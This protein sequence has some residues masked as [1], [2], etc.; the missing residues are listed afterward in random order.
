MLV[1][2]DQLF[3]VA[4]RHDYW[5]YFRGQDAVLL[6]GHRALVRRHRELV[7]LLTRNAVLAAQVF[8]GLQHPARHRV[9]PAAGRRAAPSQPVV[10]LDT[11]AGATPAHIGGIEGDVAHA[12]ATAGDDQV[13][14]AAGHLQA[15]LDHR[16]QARPAAAVDLHA[17]NRHRQAGIQRHDASDRGGLAAGVAVPQDDVLHRVGRQPGSV[18]Q[19][20]EGRDAEVN[21]TEG[22]EHSAV[23]ADRR[24]HGFTDDGLAHY[25]PSRS[26][27]RADAKAPQL[28]LKWL[29]LRLLALISRLKDAG[30]R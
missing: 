25:C 17:R 4:G 11:A 13:V 3:A 6:R 21:G 29:L 15:R 23:A 26:S 10:H 20:L 8:G 5:D 28:W 9:V 24:P 30:R 14:V 1:G 2:V 22:L 27:G 16:L 18:E 19:P 7:L 12:F